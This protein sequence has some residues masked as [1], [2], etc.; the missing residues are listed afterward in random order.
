MWPA[1]IITVTFS[2]EL[3]TE[4]RWRAICQHRTTAVSG[5]PVSPTETTGP[6]GLPVKIRQCFNEMLRETRSIP[7]LHLEKHAQTCSAKRKVSFFFFFFLFL[8]TTWEYSL[9]GRRV[10]A[11]AL[12]IKPVSSL[13]FQWCSRTTDTFCC[14]KISLI[15]RT[16]SVTSVTDWRRQ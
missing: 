9:S 1:V 15:F 8:V 16:T 12:Q 11:E 2:P 4:M 5:P 6:S 7:D 13:L 14:R 10:S 3:L